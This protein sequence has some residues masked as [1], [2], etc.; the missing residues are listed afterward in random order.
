MHSTPSNGLELLNEKVLCLNQPC[1]EGVLNKIDK[2]TK[3]FSQ[4]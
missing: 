2:Q 3:T 4:F 1:E